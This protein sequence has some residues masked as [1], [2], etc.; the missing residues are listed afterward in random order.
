MN[1]WLRAIAGLLAISVGVLIGIAMILYRMDHNL[2][3]IA[4]RALKP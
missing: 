2:M 3:V 4:V 1:C